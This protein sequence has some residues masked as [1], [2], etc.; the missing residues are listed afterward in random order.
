MNRFCAVPHSRRYSGNSALLPISLYVH[1]PF[2]TRRCPYCSFYHVGASGE[3]ES[4]FVPRLIGE[5][6]SWMEKMPAGTRLATVYFG[7]G[8][9]SI[10]AERSWSLLFRA[11]A[12]YIE[13]PSTAEI[14]CELNPEDVTDGL[15]DLLVSHG[16]NRVSLGVQSMDAGAQERLGR[17]SP[18]KNRAAIERVK[19]LFDNVSFDLLLGVPDRGGESLRRTIEQLAG[20]GPHHLSVYCLEPGGDVGDKTGGFWSR[21]DYE[22]AAD[23]YLM[24]SGYLKTRGYLHYEVS[25]FALPGF[26]CRHNR[27]YW[28]GGEYLGVG[29]AAHS[30]IGG[31]RFSNAA[32]LELYMGR[33]GEERRIRDER[34]P[35]D[36]ETEKVMLGLRTSSG[37]PVESLRCPEGVVNGILDERLAVIEGDRIRLTDRGYL[38][39]NEVVL[40]LLAR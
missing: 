16:V 22:G 11:L 39:L 40:R 12:P 7:G 26:E 20:Y 25:S 30:C 14:T 10:L 21:V 4:A 19:A 31:R 15:C 37:L 34:T 1:I 33:S 32:S 8:T 6:E 24:V 36:I 18:A 28:D 13:D 5:I 23:E 29:P 35:D 17:C 38:L 2:C 9:P 27:A 3:R